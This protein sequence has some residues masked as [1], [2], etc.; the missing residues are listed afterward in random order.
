V[1]PMQF[2]PM[3]S[4]SSLY[5]ATRYGSRGL[6]DPEARRDEPTGRHAPR[7]ASITWRI[8]VAR[9]LS[10]WAMKLDPHIGR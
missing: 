2:N 9:H 3:I 1:N 8:R 7:G 4:H 5:L 10:A 6:E